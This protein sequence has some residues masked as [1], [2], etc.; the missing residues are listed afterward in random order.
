MRADDDGRR[1]RR[2]RARSARSRSSATTRSAAASSRPCRD[3]RSPAVLMRNH[4]PFTIGKDA[5]AAVKAAVMVE[6]VARTVHIARQ[7]GDTVPIAQSDIDSLYARY[8]NVYGQ[9][10]T[11]TPESD[12]MTKPYAD[13]EIWFLTGSQGLYGEE[14]LRQVADAVAGDRRACW[15][16]VAAGEGRLEAGA[17]RLRRDPPRRAGG[18]RRRLRHRRRSRGCT[19]S[20]RPRCGSPASTRCAPRCCTCT[21]RPTSSCRGTPSTSTS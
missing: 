19:R 6:E 18:Q 17:D 8:Q 13:R 10:P 12:C 16:D 9:Q 5:K 20:P 11:N 14:T 21:R 4:G 3:S 1:V 7:L 15:S 2:R